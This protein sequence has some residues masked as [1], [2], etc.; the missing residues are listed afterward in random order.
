MRLKL[1]C[2]LATT[3]VVALL[4][5]GL[6]VPLSAQEEPPP[7]IQWLS[8]HEGSI[9]ATGSS[10]DGRTLISAGADGTI[11][12]WDRETGELIR[13]IQAGSSPVLELAVSPD[14]YQLAAGSRDSRVRVY[15]LAGR[16]PLKEMA[17]IGGVPRAVSAF[18]DG[19]RIVTGDENRLV[20][21][22]STANGQPAGDYGGMT[23][24]ITA[25]TTIPLPE[26]MVAGGEDGIILGWAYGNGTP[27]WLIY[28]TEQ[29]ALATQPVQPELNEEGNP[30]PPAHRLIAGAG[31]D[32]LLRLFHWPPVPPAS[33]PN[34]GNDVTSVSISPDG[35]LIVS[36]SL[37]QQVRLH[38]ATTNAIKLSLTGLASPV[39]STSFS[40]DGS[41]V[42]ASGAN[43]AVQFWETEKGEARSQVVGHTGVVHQVQ[44][45]PT[46]PQV[47]TAGADGTIRL[48]NLP[49]GVTPL[50]G[51][52]GAVQV[53]AAGADGKIAATAGADKTIRIWDLAENKIT[54]TVPNLEQPATALSLSPD[55]K[56]VASGDATGRLMLA[57]TAD[58]SRKESVLAHTGQ[59]SGIRWLPENAGLV[60]T[61]A[62]GSLRF[63]KL[64]LA[65]PGSLVEQP[66]VAQAAGVSPDGKAIYL[67]GADG[68]VRVLEAATGKLTK[69][70]E[71]TAPPAAVTAM[72][73]SPDGALLAAADASGRLRF[74]KTEGLEEFTSRSGHTGIIHDLRFSADGAHLATA[75]ADSTI[76]I[77]QTPAAGPEF[78][79]QAKPVTSLVSGGA[80]TPVLATSADGSIVIRSPAIADAKP[81]SQLI[82]QDVA[83]NCSAMSADG[84]LAA[85][86]LADG[87]IELIDPATGKS[88]GWLG[89]HAGGVT[90]LA[91]DGKAG[92]LASVGADGTL[93]LWKLP[94]VAGE[95]LAGV[96]EPVVALATVADGS[97]QFVATGKTIQVLQAKALKSLGAEL[98]AAATALTASADGKLLAAGTADSTLVLRDSTTGEDRLQVGTGQ[99]AIAGVG[100]H[101]QANQAATA[102]SD[103][104]IRIWDV[105]AAAVAPLAG[106]TKAITALAK[107]PNGQLLA[108]A[109]ADGT[110]RL[111]NVAD[112][113]DVRTLTGHTGPVT[114]I[115][116]RNDS[117]QLISASADGSV[118]LWT[119]GDG[120]NVATIEKPG[121]TVSSAAVLPG[122]TRI[123]TG[124]A[125][126]KIFLRT[127]ATPDEEPLEIAA[128]QKSVVRLVLLPDGN[129]LIS[130]GADGAVKS[131]ATA[132]GKAGFTASAGT[133]AT[134]LAISTDNKLLAVSTTGKTIRLFNAADGKPTGDPVVF[135]AEVSSV[136]FSPQNDRVA[137]LCSDGQLTVMEIA[138]NRLLERHQ[139]AA[140]T[141]SHV[142][143]GADARSLYAAGTAQAIQPVKLALAQLIEAST[144]PL[145]AVAFNPAGSQVVAG[146]VEKIISLWTVAN[147]AAGWKATGHTD[148]I[149]SLAY[150]ADGSKVFSGSQD[151]TARIWNA[152]NGQAAGELAH[153]SAVL[154]VSASAAPDRL[155]TASSEF[156]SSV[157]DIATGL[158]LQRVIA[159][160]GPVHAVLLSA[161]GNTVLTGGL[162]GQV[163]TEPVTAILSI[164]AHEGEA[165]AVVFTADGSQVITA[166]ADKLVKQ[167]DLTGK[168][169]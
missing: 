166:G 23:A 5:F 106:H 34:H 27:Q 168:L 116:W 12:L 7:Q 104:T 142:V 60:T 88:T 95:T 89:I 68:A 141:A 30:V 119:T 123:A 165:R 58:G 155:A 146:G 152:G 90:G 25:L 113:K 6:S 144:M 31:T 81:L 1:R 167:F 21:I 18:G 39:H 54:A 100:L 114:A 126:G 162:D 29:K 154:A 19:I 52:S 159:H 38:D 108:T 160:K 96:D 115:G 73:V 46:Q 3:A 37:D 82:A 86:G 97:R 47:A 91:F 28:S 79:R 128:H 2:R 169:V 4:L 145:N 98:P 33:L 163:R 122:G 117:A 124:M 137:A 143:F 120:K 103:G 121:G 75:G 35:S 140:E 149:T 26:M 32:G 148:A 63:W 72:A 11:R 62:D 80:G 66:Q 41:M 101:P 61:G 44:F 134:D 24:P 109:S 161:D 64:P 51:H 105:P 153:E 9:Y 74:W 111:R 16:H 40:P 138:T 57:S 85:V 45:H 87:G 20:R 84:K 102:G 125:D 13:T 131:W 133:A 136:A 139:L 150:N 147:G 59:V 107:S 94:A 67:G 15:D 56:L 93:R 99:T 83:I 135:P 110:I 70:L 36:G 112:G 14:G 157:W 8:G 164:T 65:A 92:T 69:T 43:G 50:P 78:I 132:D 55:G 71:P 129:T 17:G 127:T 151:K 22:I 130:A 10:L 48:W 158:R 118:R 77:W 49:Q 42:A 53:V 156:G 76:R